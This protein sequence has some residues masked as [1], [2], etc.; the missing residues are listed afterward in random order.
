MGYLWVVDE[1]GRSDLYETAFVP[2]IGETIHL[3]YLSDGQ[4]T[5]PRHFRVKD[6]AY[7]LCNEEKEHVEVLVEEETDSELWS[8]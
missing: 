5:A 6:V 4:P 2:R 8:S 3:E 1:S 7:H